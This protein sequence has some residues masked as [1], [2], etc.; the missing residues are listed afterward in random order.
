[1]HLYIIAQHLSISGPEE[2]RLYKLGREY[3][4]RA[5][6]VTLLTGSKDLG[7]EL[8]KRNIGLGKVDG[9]TLIALNVPYEPKMNRWQKILS[10]RRFARLAAEQGMMLPKPDLIIALAPPLTVAVPAI[11]FSEQYKVPVIVEF[12]ELWPDALV[13]QGV[14]KNSYLIRKIRK[15]EKRVFDKTDYIVTSAEEIA[16]TIKERTDGKG[17]VAVIPENLDDKEMFRIYGEIIKDLTGRYIST[18]GRLQVSSA[19]KRK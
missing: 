3:A 4:S 10:Y 17:K 1:M 15:L 2:D 19:V 14:L 9:Q 5:H 12:R 8:G 18:S 13:E 16:G 6:E 7:M 11:K